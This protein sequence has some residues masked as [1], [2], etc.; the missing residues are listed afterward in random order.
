MKESAPAFCI[1]IVAPIPS[2]TV[3]KASFIFHFIFLGHGLV[4]LLGIQSAMCVCLHCACVRAWVPSLFTFCSNMAEW[5]KVE[6]T[7]IRGECDMQSRREAASRPA[8]QALARRTHYFPPIK[9]DY[10]QVGKQVEMA[11]ARR[12][13]FKAFI[14]S[15]SF[16]IPNKNLCIVSDALMP[17]SEMNK[18][19]SECS[20]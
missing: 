13:C 11:E 2:S 3:T 12:R 8:S 18:R 6:Y 5:Y 7:T 1:K 10:F 19:R 20:E 4:S 9:G 14:G 16:W 17:K 15:F